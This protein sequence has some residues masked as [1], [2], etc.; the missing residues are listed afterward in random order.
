LGLVKPL[1]EGYTTGL[2]KLAEETKR[3]EAEAEAEAEQLGT[4]S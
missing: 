3:K 1:T 4:M 2:K